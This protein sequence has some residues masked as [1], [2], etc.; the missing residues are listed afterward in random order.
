MKTEVKKIDGVKREIA[1]SAEGDVV[2]NKFEDVFKKIGQ[3]AKV[4]GFR[5]GHAPRDILEKEFSSL[6]QEQVLRELIP[7]LYGQA[8]EKESLQV[9]DLPQISEVK[10]D[11]LNISFKALV[12]VTP[13]IEVKN[14]KGLK[15]N[16]KKITVAADEIKRH[17]DTFKEK[18]KIEVLDDKNSKSLGYP[19]L[20]ELEKAVE[21]QLAIQKENSQRNELEKQLLEQ[22]TKG[23]DFKIPQTLVNKQLEDLVRQG[24]VELALRGVP[25]EKIAEH[26]EAMHKEF[27]AQAREQV[28][29]YLVLSSIARKEKIA[30]EEH[31]P[32]KVMEFLFREANWQ[33]G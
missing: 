32:A 15:L 10:L 9:L 22:L 12:E 18:N 30:I 3:E 25:K 6:A 23:L 11:R 19:N 14:Y 33:V 2:K 7:E 31:M 20:E 16:Y 13:E 17:L 21:R 27:E 4:K 1:I 28:K 26:E 24:K 8:I 5:P 29:V